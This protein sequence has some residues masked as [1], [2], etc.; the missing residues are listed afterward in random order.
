MNQGLEIFLR[1]L[2]LLSTG[3][4]IAIA[5]GD[6]RSLSK[7]Y[8]VTCNF[9]ARSPPWGSVGETAMGSGVIRYVLLRICGSLQAYCRWE[10]ARGIRF[11][12]GDAEPSVIFVVQDMAIC[13][14]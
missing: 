4:Q 8:Q 12:H 13:E 10:G 5:N 1:R 11:S 9:L 3:I 2:G 6:V 7:V 14:E